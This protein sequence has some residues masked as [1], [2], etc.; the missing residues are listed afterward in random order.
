M[1]HSLR[2]SPSRLTNR[3]RATGSVLAALVAA[4]GAACGTSDDQAAPAPPGGANAS[5]SNRGTPAELP[6]RAKRQ[7]DSLRRYKGAEVFVLARRDE[8]TF[9]RLDG[10]SEGMCFALGAGDSLGQVTCDQSGSLGDV[11]DLSIVDIT[12]ASTGVALVALDGV[13]SDRVSRIDVI[14]PVGR[15]IA[16]VPVTANVYHWKPAS[17]VSARTAIAIGRDGT[18]IKDL[19]RR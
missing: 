14:D 5:M 7:L 16:A 19:W 4:F 6:P 2:H 3:A 15:V 10:T 13:T 11:L 9:Y 1:S 18:T 12:P 17:P 8:R